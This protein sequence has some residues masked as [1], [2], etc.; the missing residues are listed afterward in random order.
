MIRVTKEKC[1][2]DISTSAK[3]GAI[4]VLGICQISMMELFSENNNIFAKQAPS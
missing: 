4:V 1:I 2:K 3:L